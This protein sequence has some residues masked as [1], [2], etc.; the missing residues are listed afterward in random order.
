[1]REVFEKI[2]DKLDRLRPHG[3]MGKY[4]DEICDEAISIVKEVAEEYNNGWIPVSSGKLPE[5]GDKLFLVIANG[6]PKSN[7]TFDNAVEL[8]TYDKECG[9][10]LENYPEAENIEIIA[11]QPLP[12][13]YQPKGDLE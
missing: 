1:M 8:A 12:E 2:L 6:K 11:W 10:I 7:I 5:D 4:A 13:K 3:I 9:W